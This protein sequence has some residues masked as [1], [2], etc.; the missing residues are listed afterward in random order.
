MASA[1]QRADSKEVSRQVSAARERKPKES[2]GRKSA[3]LT[4]MNRTASVKEVLRK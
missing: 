1:A 4:R 2:Q 3:V